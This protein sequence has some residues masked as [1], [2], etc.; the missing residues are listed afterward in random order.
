MDGIRTSPEHFFSSFP[1]NASAICTEREGQSD[2]IHVTKRVDRLLQSLVTQGNDLIC[3]GEGDL[4]ASS[5]S[6]IVYVAEELFELRKDLVSSVLS[7]VT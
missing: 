2:I 7:R 5:L 4:Q 3:R 6:S 1:E